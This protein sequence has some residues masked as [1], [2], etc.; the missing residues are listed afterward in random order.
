MHPCCIDRIGYAYRGAFQYR[1]NALMEVEDYTGP[2]NAVDS[3]R[4]YLQ[5]A[6]NVQAV[7]HASS[8][9]AITRTSFCAFTHDNAK[10][11]SS[12]GG[13]NSMQCSHEMHT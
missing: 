10:E 2:M 4:M 6:F 1:T 12:C 11:A 9:L 13:I 3:L 7:Q 5:N 8:L